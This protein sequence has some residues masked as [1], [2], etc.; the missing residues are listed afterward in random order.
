MTTPDPAFE[1]IDPAGSPSDPPGQHPADHPADDPIDRLLDAIELLQSESDAQRAA[2]RAILRGL[3]SADNEFEAAWLWMSVA[4]DNLDQAAV[5]L[6]NVLRINPRNANAAAALY[7]IRLRDRA[8]L[9][10]QQRLRATRDSAFALLWVCIV[11]TLC[12]V[13]TTFPVRPPL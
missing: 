9:K 8:A 2:A 7:R 5:C 12:A 4:V 6:D 10:R 1:P 11:G 13:L 3:I